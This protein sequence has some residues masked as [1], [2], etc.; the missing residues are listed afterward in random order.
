MFRKLVDGIILNLLVWFALL[1][2]KIT[3]YGGN[4][5]K[6][7]PFLG[8]LYNLMREC[9]HENAVVSVRKNQHYDIHPS[10]RWGFD[11]KL[12]GDGYISVGENTYFGRDCHILSNTPT[13]KIIIGK[14]CAISHNVNIRTETHKKVFQFSDER[15]SPP[16]GA[17]III[18]DYVWIGA[19]VFI[20]GGVTI[21]ENSIIGANSVVTGDIPANTIYGGLPAR[22]IRDKS[23][24]LE[25][26]P[27][28][29][30]PVSIDN[31][32]NSEE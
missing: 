29:P 9:S 16:A 21:G 1:I 3:L 30:E 5:P 25:P 20:K 12:Y 32:A 6:V 13:T 8:K 22:F 19:N 17:D 10:V 14:H 15:Y 4:N 18:G 31:S 24:Y 7:K 11:T 26:I 27:S 2:S 23:V 28:N